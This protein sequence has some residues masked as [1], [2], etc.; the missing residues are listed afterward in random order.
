M[1]PG[2]FPCEA[3]DG[4]GG[5]EREY[6][7]RPSD[8]QRRREAFSMADPD[9]RHPLRMQALSATLSARVGVA[10]VTNPDGLCLFRCLNRARSSYL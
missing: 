8:I 4:G 10:I 9:I 3:G 1:T 6:K 2:G 5:G 7:P